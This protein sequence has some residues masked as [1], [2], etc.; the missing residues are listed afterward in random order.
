MGTVTVCR[1]CMSAECGG[2]RGSLLIDITLE[3]YQG[4]T[5]VCADCDRVTACGC[6]E[7]GLEP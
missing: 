1:E 4:R 6:G 2:D 7:G 5:N 3:Q